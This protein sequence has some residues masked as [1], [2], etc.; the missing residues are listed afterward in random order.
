[1]KSLLM[2]SSLLFSLPLWAANIYVAPVQG[3]N[4]SDQD[5]K[6][7][8]ELVKVEVQN[9]S[10]HRLVDNLDQAEFFLQTKVIKF[11]SY[12]LSLTKWQ[13]N[14]KINSG[15]WKANNLS[16]LE[17]QVSLAVN[18]V[19]NTSSNT[20]SAVLYEDKK[21][22][23]GDRAAEKNEQS[24]FTRVEARRQVILGF[25]AAYFG[26]MNTSEAALGFQGGVM[27]TIDDHF[28]LGLKSD[29]AISTDHSDAYMFSGQ[30][31]TNYHFTR[32]DISPFVGAGFGYGWASVHDANQPFISDDTAAGFSLGLQAGVKFFRTST[33]NF[34]ISGE[35]NHIFN[36]TSLG[37]PSVF[38]LKVGLLY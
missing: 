37:N 28:D 9:D 4:V 35:Y 29:F 33:V 30:I 2:I 1:M 38:L 32:Q 18:D 22:S 10:N 14:N 31:L 3:T 27:W 15:Q 5:S 36:E 6:T 34:T 8:R 16:D 21:K 20:R 17:K 23:L 25:G 24:N 7:I 11:D 13:G 19:L 26:N 12:T